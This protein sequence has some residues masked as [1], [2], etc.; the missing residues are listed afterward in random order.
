MYTAEQLAALAAG[1][2]LESLGLKAPVAP[3][4]SEVAAAVETVVAAATTT[5][6][7]VEAAAPAVEQKPEIV[8]FLQ[9]QLADAQEA[10]MNAKVE[11]A[12]LKAKATETSATYEGLMSVARASVG[13]LSVALGGSATAAAALNATEILAEHARLETTFK[14]QY[15]VGGVAAQTQE[16]KPTAALLDPMF[17]RAAQRAAK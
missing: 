13:K 8:A 9:S 16:V 15:K 7:V 2:S 12:S 14:E 6:P 4:K 3:A 10:L 1:A 5:A 17:V 11:N